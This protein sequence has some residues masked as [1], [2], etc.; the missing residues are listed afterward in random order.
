MCPCETEAAV[1]DE[2]H[3]DKEAKGCVVIRA[4][5]IFL[6]GILTGALLA[7]AFPAAARAK[8]AW[9][10]IDPADLA[11]KDNPAKPGSAAMI[12]YREEDN[13]GVESTESEYYRIKIFTAEGK[14]WGNVE[15]PYLKG[16]SEV[17]DIRA[18]TVLPTGSIVPFSGTIFDKVVVKASGIKV[19]EKTFSLPDVQ[20][21]CIIEY[22]YRLQLDPNY[23]YN[24]RWR[25]Q[26]DL[27]TRLARFSIRPF[28]GAGALYWRTIRVNQLIKPQ[29][30]NDGTFA[31]ELH[32]IPA[33]V[34]EDYMLPE[35]MIAGRVEFYYRRQEKLSST[36]DYWKKFDKALNISIDKFIDKKGALEKALAQ[37]VSPN[38]SPEVKLQKIYARAQQIRNLSYEDKTY[39]ELKREKLK[40]N[41]NIQDVLKHGY[42]SGLAVNYLFLALARTA[43]FKANE[44][45][46]A[47]R[48]RGIFDPKLQ[49][50]RQLSAEVVRVRL[51]PQDLYLD[52]ASRYY[53]Y[54]LL[55]WFETAAKGL[56][57]NKEGGEFVA[58]PAPK[59]SDAIT[60]R[61]GTLALGADGTL[62]GQLEVDFIGRL[63]CEWREDE[64]LDDE[65][66]RR[67]DMS[68]LVLGGLPAGAT[69]DV[70][71]TSGWDNS[72]QPLRIIGTL[73]VPGFGTPAGRR[74]LVTMTPFVAPESAA[75]RSS[76]RVNAIYFH[77]PYQD[78]DDLTV[79]LPPGFRVETMPTTPE[80]PSGAIR[81]IVSAVEQ[82]NT[83]HLTRRLEV[84]GFYY[85]V[86]YYP[87]LR[88]IF[89]TAREGDDADI[90]FDSAASAQKH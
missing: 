24:S 76:T 82:G 77:F 42:A 78:H 21:G 4:S 81:Y 31:V 64:R 50:T 19:Y 15:I 5:H 23:Y 72:A 8:K 58:I 7:A 48:S 87:A 17:K 73:K 33:I 36:E 62:T 30:Q 52:P 68:K 26:D 90:V 16:Q 88:Q 74:M 40:D 9:L 44:V 27:Y 69:F 54:G 55:P 75:F 67:K 3:A 57:V 29:K 46:V 35:S 71:S 83:L 53:P 14:K 47:S 41:N 49:D 11:L 85:A 66:G 59:S 65:T 89:N 6:P 20:P 60:E 38:D 10:P 43:G 45:W 28:I 12:L 13:D 32:D 80:V 86:D 70:A 18:R 2:P 39:Q 51:G 56:L 63:G 61:H 1:G 25:L 37:T 34:K 84:D 22:K 79:S